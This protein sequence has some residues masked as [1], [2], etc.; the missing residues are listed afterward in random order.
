MA[1][2]SKGTLL[3]VE[4]TTTPGTYIT[5]A[6]RTKIDGPEIKVDSV[7][8]THLDSAMMESRPSD[9]AD[10][11]EIS[12]TVNYDPAE[13]THITLE[14]LARTP[15]T[16]NWRL[17]YNNKTNTRP[18]RQFAGYVTSFKPTGFEVGS[19]PTADLTIKL[20]GPVTDGTT[21]LT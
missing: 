13:A 14:D 19:R 7:D 16:V 12:F 1:I 21:T 6:F 15:E 17:V 3:Q 4:D 2:I 20:T 9:F 8:E 10:P 11:G 5:I 18:H